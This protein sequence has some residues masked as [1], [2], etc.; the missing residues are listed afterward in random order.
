MRVI[1]GSRGELQQD[2]AP[3]HANGATSDRAYLLEKGESGGFPLD[4]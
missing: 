2:A 3:P 4:G 1:A